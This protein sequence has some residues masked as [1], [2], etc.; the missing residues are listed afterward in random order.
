MLDFDNL[1]GAQ[2]LIDY[3]AD[4]NE[5]APDHPSGE[6]IPTISALHQAARRGRDGRFAELL[7]YQRHDFPTLARFPNQL[8]SDSRLAQEICHSSRC[9]A[10]PAF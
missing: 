7:L 8:N 1:E 3:G 5:F 9:S 6:P 4:P 2:L 10:S